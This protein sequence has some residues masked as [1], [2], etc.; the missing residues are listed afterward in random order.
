MISQAERHRTAV[1]LLVI[2]FVVMGAG[3]WLWIWNDEPRFGFVVVLG[4]FPLSYG[5]RLIGRGASGAL[6]AVGGLVSASSNAWTL[7]HPLPVD[8]TSFWTGLIFGIVVAVLGVVM[9]VQE[10]RKGNGA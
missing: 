1:K 5:L 6:M 8:H 10:R 7:L 3:A 9:A 2:S 4:V